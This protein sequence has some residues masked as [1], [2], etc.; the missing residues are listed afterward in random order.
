MLILMVGPK[1]TGEYK[2]VAENP[3]GRAECSTKLTVRGEIFKLP[4]LLK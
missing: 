4:F 2:V 3:L 1:D